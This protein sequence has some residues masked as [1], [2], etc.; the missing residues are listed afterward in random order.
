MDNFFTNYEL[1]QVLRANGLY[2]V[3]TVRSNKRF[4]PNE[5]KKD[6]HRPAGQNLFGFRAKHTL[7]SHVPRKNKSVIF[8]STLHHNGRIE[9]DGMAEINSFYNKTKAGVDVLDQ[10]CHSYSVQRKT[11]RWSFAYFMNLLNVGGV[12]AYVLW[13]TANGKLNE[14][15][16]KERKHFLTRLYTEL[17]YEHIR[18]RSVAGLSKSQQQMIRGIIGDPNEPGPSGPPQK[19]GKRRCHLC[20]HAKSRKIKQICEVCKRNVC[21]E[22][23]TAIIR[24]RECKK[25]QL[26]TSRMTNRSTKLNFFHFRFD[27]LIFNFLIYTCIS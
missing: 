23:A 9:N 7:L 1:F 11:N 16:E 2:A 26:S 10:L 24:C 12:A 15:T 27:K 3:G 6:R 20:P 13:R 18:R 19:K 4:V 22:H 5:F 21:K 8:L 14:P 17:T 25:S